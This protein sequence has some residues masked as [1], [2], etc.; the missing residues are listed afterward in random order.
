MNGVNTAFAAQREAT[1][2]IERLRREVAEAEAAVNRLTSHSPDEEVSAALNLAAA[3]TLRLRL[4]REEM[5]RRT[6]RT[7]SSMNG[8]ETR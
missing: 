6:V 1:S 5:E 7:I 2:H 8:K 3:R 4:A